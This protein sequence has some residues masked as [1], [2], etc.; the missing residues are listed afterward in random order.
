MFESAA[1]ERKPRFP[2]WVLPLA[3]VVLGGI[4]AAFSY[5]GAINRPPAG[6]LTGV[7]HAPD[8]DYHWY[9]KYV[10]LESRGIK[11]GKNFAGKRMVIF[12]GVVHN[13][14]ER[15]LDV[16]QVKLT[17]FNHDE[18]VYEVVK[19]ALRP[20]PYTPPLPSLQDR[21][22]TI[23]LEDIPGQWRAS[24]AEMEITGFRFA[25]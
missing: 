8:P 21:A 14:G 13:E 16:V 9:S 10:R 23:Y 7:L 2:W 6:P 22:F 20:G 24:N 4:V 5:F 17:L 19:E 18:A 25:E 12:S 11:L 1:R 3:V 15:I